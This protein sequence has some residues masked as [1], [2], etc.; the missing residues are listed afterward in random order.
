MLWLNFV[1]CKQQNGLVKWSTASESDND[2]FTIE[3]SNDLEN[4]QEIAT[5]NG[6]GNSTSI[7]HY[8]FEIENLLK[9][10]SGYYRLKQTDFNG[11]FSYSDNQFFEFC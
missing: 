9:E 1:E 7:I 3:K 5:I 4:W 8:M 11:Q 10:K 2:Y 6:A